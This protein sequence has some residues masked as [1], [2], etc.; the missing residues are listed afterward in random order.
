MIRNLYPAEKVDV[1]RVFQVVGCLGHGRGK[2]KFAVQGALVRWLV[3][4][5][6]VVGV[7]GKKGLDGAY[8]VLFNLLDTMQL[9]YDFFYLFL[10][11]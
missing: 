5:Y 3:C 9:R 8:G 10:F 6:E 2:P 1:D 11:F 4:V 7:D